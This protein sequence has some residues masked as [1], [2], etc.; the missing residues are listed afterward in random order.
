MRSSALTTFAATAA[1]VLLTFATSIILARNLGPE[2]RGLLLALTF[3][4]ALISALTNLSLNEAAAYHIARSDGMSDAA[5]KREF[6]AT[7]LL[8]QLAM[9][10]VSGAICVLVIDLLLPAAHRVS[11][12]AVLCYAVLFAPLSVLDQHFKAVLQGRGQF[13]L[14]NAIR[15][16]QPLAYA[17]LLVLLVIL[18]AVSVGSVMAAM[19]A[20]LAVSPLVVALVD[21]APV[22][23]LS[24]AA[25]SKLV[26][27]GLR[28]HVANFVLYAATEIDKLIVLQLV[29]ISLVGQY[30]IAIGVSSLGSGLVVQSVGLLLSREMSALR[31]LQ[32]RGE[33]LIRGVHV[34]TIALVLVNGA[35]AAL[36]PWWLPLVFGQ[37]FV[38]AVPV[39]MV[40][41]L[42]GTLR[43][44]RQIIDRGMR[45]AHVTS[46][47]ITGEAIALVAS[48]VFA[49]L[50]CKLGSLLGLAAGLALAQACACVVTFVMV[51]RHFNLKLVHF[52]PLQAAGID[53]LVRALRK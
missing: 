49:T 12:W 27:S 11:L 23:P 52:W 33:L 41:L 22:V 32:H 2:G 9:A 8:L 38:P 15:L 44:I 21:G 19:I 40:L 7:G 53:N 39:A 48:V 30:A 13:I 37:E 36:A 4:P 3:W 18:S 47:G 51:A 31:D 46:T 1:I 50:G 10:F 25:A 34:T 26:S 20:S 45:A 29:D 24:R 28:F 17:T 35:A 5:A 16:V 14:L 42:M 43:G 6:E